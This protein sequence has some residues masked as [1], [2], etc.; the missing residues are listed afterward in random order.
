MEH[1]QTGKHNGQHNGKTNEINRNSGSSEPALSGA[2]GRR[3]RILILTVLILAAVLFLSGR[4]L[5]SEPAA[6]VEIAVVQND[7]TSS[8]KIVLETFPLNRDT[9]YTIR[10][11]PVLAGEPEGINHLV[12]RDGKAW[13]DSANCPGHDCIKQGT[14][15]RNG[16]ML[17]CIPHRLTVEVK[18]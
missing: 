11:A 14:I 5:F 10:T 9:E 16:D 13:I 15:S 17:I 4:F 3:D 18:E 2:F 8:E 6:V 7:G 12:I 1:P